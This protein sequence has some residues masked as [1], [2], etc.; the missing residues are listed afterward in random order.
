MI[1]RIV[2]S[3]FSR[4]ILGI[5]VGVLLSVSAVL[6]QEPQGGFVPLS[7]APGVQV[8]RIPAA[9]LLIASYAFFLVLMMFYLWTIWSRLGKV[10]KEMRELE[11][12]Q[13]TAKR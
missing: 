3:G 9:P 1:R 8:E 4:T 12:R 10:E 7:Q 5:V 11:R 2:G 6:A 13:G